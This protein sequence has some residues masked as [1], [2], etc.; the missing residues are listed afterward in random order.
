MSCSLEVVATALRTSGWASF[1]A[2]GAL[3]PGSYAIDPIHRCLQKTDGF[4]RP[5]YRNQQLHAVGRT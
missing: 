3:L 2:G 1:I 5:G 4:G